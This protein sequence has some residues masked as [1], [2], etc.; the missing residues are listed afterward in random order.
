MSVSNKHSANEILSETLT[1]NDRIGR[2]NGEV[3]MEFL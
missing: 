3:G 1:E 2:E